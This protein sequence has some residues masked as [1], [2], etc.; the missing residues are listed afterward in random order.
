MDFDVE[1]FLTRSGE[2]GFVF[3][4][5]EIRDDYFDKAGEDDDEAEQN[6]LPIMNFETMTEGKWKHEARWKTW[7]IKEVKPNPDDKD[8]RYPY[9]AA[10]MVDD[11]TGHSEVWG[12]KIDGDQLL[13]YPGAAPLYTQSYGSYVP[14]NYLL[15]RSPDNDVYERLQEYNLDPKL[16]SKLVG[17]NEFWLHA[18]RLIYHTIAEMQLRNAHLKA[19][20]LVEA[21]Q[22]AEAQKLIEDKKL[23]ANGN[24]WKVKRLDVYKNPKLCYSKKIR[25]E[26][27]EMIADSA[28]KANEEQDD[29]VVQHYLATAEDEYYEGESADGI[30]EA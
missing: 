2:Y 27:L 28:S 22:L 29:G 21:Q 6:K 15:N 16:G 25:D 14:L 7:N 17:G 23:K 12:A 30:E 13:Q 9:T 19:Q 4:A 24:L 20:Q 10:D 11:S 26:I 18:F 5:L 8:E 3:E 1:W